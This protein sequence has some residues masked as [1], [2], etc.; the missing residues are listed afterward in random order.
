MRQLLRAMRKSQDFDQ[1]HE[2]IENDSE[3]Y[4]MAVEITVKL[5]DAI[6]RTV[7]KKG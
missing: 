7:E 6:H 3:A 5:A 2:I 1:L 4:A